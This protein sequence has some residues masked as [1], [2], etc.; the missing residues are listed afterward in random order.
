M[1]DGNY[2]GQLTSSYLLVLL[3]GHSSSMLGLSIYHFIDVEVDQEN[4]NERSKT[5]HTLSKGYRGLKNH[6]K[7]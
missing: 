1:Q 3:R 2:T 6:Y 7:N 4:T 5:G